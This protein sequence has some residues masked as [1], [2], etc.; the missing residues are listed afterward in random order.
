MYVLKTGSETEWC[1]KTRL[2]FFRMSL[3]FENWFGN[4]WLSEMKQIDFETILNHLNTRAEIHQAPLS[5]FSL[6]AA[7]LTVQVP[8]KDQDSC[9]MLVNLSPDYA[10]WFSESHVGALLV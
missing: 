3:L 10:V 8:F 4:Q 7:F 9:P 6:V 2:I 1:A 5:L